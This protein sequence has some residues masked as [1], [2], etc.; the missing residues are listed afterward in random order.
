MT[1]DVVLGW[2]EATIFPGPPAI[3]GAPP[4]IPAPLSIV[5]S[6]P[7]QD[8]NPPQPFDPDGGSP[9]VGVL[10]GPAY[11][12]WAQGFQFLPELLGPAAGYG[13]CSSIP[14]NDDEN[15]TGPQPV[16]VF[17]V[18]ESDIRADS[19][20]KASDA[21]KRVVR[22]LLGHESW[23]VENEWWRGALNPDNAH[24]NM[25][26]PIYP[27]TY[28]GD[29]ADAAEGLADSLGLLEEVIAETDAGQGIIHCTPFVF[30]AWAT[31]GGI[32]FRYD[33]GNPGNSAHI[34]TPNGNLVIPGYG[35]D[36]SAP[37]DIDADQPSLRYQR[38]QWAYATDMVYLL[39]GVIVTEPNSVSEM[40][41]DM[42]TFSKV[43]WRATR[44]WA[45]Y[46]N[47]GCR[48]AVLVDTTTI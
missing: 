12:R 13:W 17:E 2:E 48:A 43:P 24:L 39:R 33:G 11:E 34:Y 38:Q 30:N 21:I 19:G 18:V 7:I 46:S 14:M 35:Y 31:R 16:S 26:N 36:G 10:G 8:S 40:S 28:Q 15:C 42:P 27:S 37:A 6:C 20:I 47:G 41:P 45:I 32:P 22:G 23:R 9:G 44:P 4:L 5:T 25:P 1:V 29:D 3:V